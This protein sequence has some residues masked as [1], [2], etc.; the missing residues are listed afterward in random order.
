MGRSSSSTGLWVLFIVATF[1]VVAG[2]VVVAIFRTITA[3]KAD[4]EQTERTS[5]W[6]GL[7]SQA[8]STFVDGAK[9]AVGAA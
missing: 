9:A 4:E 1:L 8:L 5:G 6:L 7:L 2:A 3:R